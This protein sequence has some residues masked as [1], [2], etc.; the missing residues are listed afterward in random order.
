MKRE[1]VSGM[2]NIVAVFV[3][4]HH[5]QDWRCSFGHQHAGTLCFSRVDM[6]IAAAQQL[7]STLLICGDSNGGSDVRMLVAHAQHHGVRCVEGLHKSHSNTVM[8][9]QSTIDYIAGLSTTGRIVLRLV[10]DWWHMPRVI[11]QTQRAIRAAR[12]GP[13]RVVLQPHSVLGW[14]PPAKVLT[15]EALGVTD[16]LR[17]RPQQSRGIPVGKPDATARH[18]KRAPDTS[19]QE[20]ERW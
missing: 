4:P 18:R 10:T 2:E 17:G 9:A 12:I 20:G 1:T 15:G 3:G 16:A 5:V 7:G 6:G 11:I 14:I 13:D 19:S 8:D